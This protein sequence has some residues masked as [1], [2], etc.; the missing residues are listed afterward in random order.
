VRF[1]GAGRYAEA[2]G[3]RPYQP[4]GPGRDTLAAWRRRRTRRVVAV[5]AGAVLA[6][7]GLGAADRAGRFGV[8]GA[9]RGALEGRWRAVD[10][11]DVVDGLGPVLRLAGG[12]DVGL[13]GLASAAGH[14]PAAADAVRGWIGGGRVRVRFPRGGTRD[15]AGRRVARVETAGGVVLNEALLIAGLAR[16]RR[17]ATHPDAE[18]YVLLARQARDDAERAAAV[19]AEAVA[20]PRGAGLELRP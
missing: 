14:G 19:A 20:E 8:T 4:A 10:A 17:A 18:R 2:M 5:A 1:A 7:A 13:L 6:A 3:R 12:V 15:A 16:P 11:V 9:D